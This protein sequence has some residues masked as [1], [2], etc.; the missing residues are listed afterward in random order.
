MKAKPKTAPKKRYAGFTAEEKSAMANRV[1]E[2]KLGDV[3]MES[4]VQ[5]KIAEMTESDRAMAQRI[6][7]IIKA[8]VPTIEARLWYGMPAYAVRGKTICFF[9]PAKKFKTRYA[10]LGFN[11]PA[12][13]DDGDLWATAYAVTKITPDVEAKIGALVKKAAS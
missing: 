10:T 1:K 3:E 5:E 6:H 12:H 13:L 4:Q 11:D 8:K 2:M 7:E 9:Q